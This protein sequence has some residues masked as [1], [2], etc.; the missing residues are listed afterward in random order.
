MNIRG[1]PGTNYPIIGEASSGDAATVTGRNPNNTWFEIEYPPGSGNTGWVFAEL[2]E[3][4]GNPASVAIAQLPAPPPATPTETPTTIPTRT[5]TPQF[6][7]QFTAAGWSTLPNQAI[8]QLKG[9]IKDEAGNPVN[10]YSVL[11]DNGSF[12]VLSH[13]TGASHHY[14]EKFDGEWDIVLYDPATATGNWTLTVVSYD[15]PNFEQRFDAQC[16]QFTR[17][18]EDITVRLE[19]PDEAILNADWICHRDCD[20]GLY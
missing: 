2:V 9:T 6:Q 17:L 16:K 19:T 11:A 18:S 14:P 4:S 3:I 7:F 5:P 8:I 10:G 12:S 20:Q 13:P 1:G 15:C